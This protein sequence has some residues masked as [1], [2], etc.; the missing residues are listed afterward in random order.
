M[1][2]LVARTFGWLAAAF[3][4]LLLAA[5][6]QDRG[7]SIHLMIAC[8]AALLAAVAQVKNADYALIGGAIARP[9]G[10][11][12]TYDDEPIRWGVVATVFWGVVGFLVGLDIALQLTFPALNLESEFT[13]FG[14]LRPLH[15][16]AVIFAFGGNALIA[17]RCS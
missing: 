10:V 17:S 4:A 3:L 13:T 2:N 1:E 15:T 9:A 7:F 14:R 16:S 11:S 5:V 6:A 12:D 8:G